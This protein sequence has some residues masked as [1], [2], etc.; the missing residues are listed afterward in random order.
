MDLILSLLNE[1]LVFQV[2]SSESMRGSN[3]LRIQDPCF[4]IAADLTG[5]TAGKPEEA[6]T[7]SLPSQTQF[8][9]SRFGAGC[10]S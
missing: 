5:D 3:S 2:T 10:Q 6:M 7:S 1:R 4:H 8:W 9:H